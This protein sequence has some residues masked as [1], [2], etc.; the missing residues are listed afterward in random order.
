MD[1]ELSTVPIS[2]SSGYALHKDQT[3]CA[4]LLASVKA[5][6]P[7]QIIRSK[8][9]GAGTGLSVTNNVDF[10]QEL[11]RSRPVVNCVEDGYQ[12]LVC[13]YCYVYK[14]SKL[15]SSGRIRT[16][17]DTKL[18]VK[19]CNACHA[20][21]YCSKTCQQK[22]WKLYHK[23]ECAMFLKVPTISPRGRV[24]Y[25]IL[26]LHKQKLFSPDQ[27]RSLRGLTSHTTE[28][29]RSTISGDVIG[30]ATHAIEN[31]KT[32]LSLKEVLAVYCSILTNCLSIYQADGRMLGTS[33]DIVASLINHS[34]DPNTFVVFEG[35]ELRV[36][37]IRKISAGE[38]ITQC[39][40]DID[41]DVLIRRSVLKSEY[42]F[43]CCCARCKSQM[44]SH[45]KLFPE[46]I[47]Q[48]AQSQQQL[49]QITNEAVKER[50]VDI[51]ESQASTITTAAFPDGQWPE[52]L[53]PWPSSRIRLA[54]IHQ[55]HGR[56]IEALKYA[57]KGQLL[58]E[59]RSGD[60]WTRRLFSLVQY[61]RDFLMHQT[62][63]R[64]TDFPTEAQ[65]KDV[66]Y[67]YLH[68]LKTYA[69]KTFGEKT[70][71]AQSI[72]WYYDDYVNGGSA[73]ERINRAFARRFNQAQAKLLVWAG[74]EQNRAIALT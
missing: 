64:D 25:R 54:S 46:R 26:N 59:H 23:L 53:A 33:L 9:S 39:Y 14:D 51:F 47:K 38:E 24:L 29:L 31:T 73:P 17:E 49:L 35:G 1:D 15:N 5:A 18:D 69:G 57:L 7:L 65:M 28:Y 45:Q 42:F 55:A 20:C 67:G 48:V 62:I 19:A 27:W 8:I 12:H 43:H 52:D 68:V 72:L 60:R 44:Q 41:M 3:L 50:N 34:C 58:L 4:E 13:D 70:R 30:F 71:Y 11:F 16:A 66:M 6:A 61:F 37:P 56:R 32:S 2:I 10:G 63:C 74:V 40:T 22:A 36:R 21:Y